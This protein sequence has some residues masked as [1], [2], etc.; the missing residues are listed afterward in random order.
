[1]P[2]LEN[3]EINVDDKFTMN[4]IICTQVERKTEVYSVN[5]CALISLKT[6]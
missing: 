4:P 3:N 1:M 5:V 2:K 6:Q